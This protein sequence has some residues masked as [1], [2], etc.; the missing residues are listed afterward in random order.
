MGFGGER[1]GAVSAAV[2]EAESCAYGS[3]FGS[4]SIRLQT[5]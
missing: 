2:Q 3:G 1:V 4:S 5:R